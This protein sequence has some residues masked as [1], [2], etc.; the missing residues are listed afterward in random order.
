[1][2]QDKEV[3]VS[4]PAKLAKMQQTAER[5][6]KKQKRKAQE[7]K[8]QIKRKEMDKAKVNFLIASALWI[9]SNRD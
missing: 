3:N 8:L 2:T 1:V 5:R 9:I 4:S 6:E 7:G